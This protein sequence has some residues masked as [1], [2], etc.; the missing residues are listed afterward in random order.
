MLK[1]SDTHTCMHIYYES[2]TRFS[3]PTHSKMHANALWG[4]EDVREMEGKGGRG[5]ERDGERE[6]EALQTVY[7][8][9]CLSVWI[10]DFKVSSDSVDSY[11]VF[12][13][14]YTH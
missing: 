12:S 11:Q 8:L 5:G 13:D 10:T 14:T 2:I 6:T 1:L 4:R 3:I 9:S 7:Q